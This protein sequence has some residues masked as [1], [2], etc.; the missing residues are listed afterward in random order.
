[1]FVSICH[2]AIKT[3]KILFFLGVRCVVDLKLGISKVIWAKPGSEREG[4]KEYETEDVS[5]TTKTLGL[6]NTEG[7]GERIRVG[8][9]L[10]VPSQGCGSR[11]RARDAVFK[12]A[13]HCEDCIPPEGIKTSRPLWTQPTQRLEGHKNKEAVNSKCFFCVVCTQTFPLPGMRSLLNS[14]LL[15]GDFAISGCFMVRVERTEFG[16]MVGM[17]PV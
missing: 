5:F 14:I 9:G 15:E 3:I 10:A 8:R 13:E 1:M 17:E 16:F 4:E 12:K 2:A 7:S 11:W 6:D